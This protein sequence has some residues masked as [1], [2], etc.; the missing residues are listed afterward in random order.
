[1]APRLLG[2]MPP[3]GEEAVESVDPTA[4]NTTRA[5]P[6]R[7][8]GLVLSVGAL[9]VAALLAAATDIRISGH[10]Q[11]MFLLR[12]KEGLPLVVQDDVFL[13]DGSRLVAGFSFSRV[14]QVLAS[15]APRQ[16]RAWLELD[17]DDAD[18]SGLV[19]NHLAEGTELVTDFSRYDDDEGK[20][21]QGLF[22]GG[23]LPEVAAGEEQDESGMSFHD[24]RGWHHVWCNVNELLMDLD[25]RRRWSPG[26]WTYLGARV[27]I[28]D[29]DRV[30][31]ES[32]HAIPVLGG[33]L[34]VD[35]FAYF[36]AGKPWFKLGIR[37]VNTGDRPVRYAY[38][39]GDEPWVGHF[40]SSA[41]NVGWVRDGIIRVEVLID[42]R[43]NRW[44][45]IL[46]EESGI[47]DF[48]AWVGEVMPDRVYFANQ[49]G[50]RFER[51]GQPLDSNAVFV[52]LE[53]LDQVL[54]PGEQRS[55]LISLGLARPDAS[56][57]PVLPEGAG[58][59]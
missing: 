50:S 49:P 35:R 27:L 5:A 23:A 1:V 31:I 36:A 33:A 26:S 47:A 54:R 59:P 12:G 28:R 16:G 55:Y 51:L 52:G 19:R 10:W 42:A 9:G 13:G 34:R 21:P 32:S 11:G 20:N 46:D 4:A 30:V 29:P 14:R 7:R 6:T 56:G 17:W 43:A 18:G 45:G 38:A 44:A 39:Y 25:S 40:G 37:V 2:R 3:A 24:A 41:G 48:I 58:P 22:V 57:I 53:W 8:V 15:G